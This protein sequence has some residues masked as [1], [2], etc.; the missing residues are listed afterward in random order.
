MPNGIA[1]ATS[2]IAVLRNKILV[3]LFR[4]IRG[5]IPRSL[6]R[7]HFSTKYACLIFSQANERSIN[8]RPRPARSGS[9]AGRP[10]WHRKRRSS[11]PCP[12]VSRSKGY[13]LRKQAQMV[14][15]TCSA[16][17]S[18]MPHSIQAWPKVRYFNMIVLMSR[19]KTMLQPTQSLP[20]TW[21]SRLEWCGNWRSGS[22][23]LRGF[24]R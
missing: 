5:S 10:R 12:G 2:A 21:P 16:A 11:P 17:V 3:G 1:I 24:T 8:F 14:L 13:C 15:S 18:Q 4:P 20:K 19:R 23:P 6:P 9:P 22:A 7:L